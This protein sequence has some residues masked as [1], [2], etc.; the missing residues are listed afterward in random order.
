ME[1]LVVTIG[2]LATLNRQCKR[3]ALKVRKTFLAEYIREG[4]RDAGA[5]EVEHD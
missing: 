1:S 4:L 5:I 3:V 2:E